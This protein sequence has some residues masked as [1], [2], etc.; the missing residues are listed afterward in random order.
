VIDQF[1][2]YEP[3]EGAETR[4]RTEA[5]VAYDDRYLYIHVRMFDPAPDSI[6]SL[7]ARRDVR[8][9]S[10][11]LKLVIDSYHDRRTAYQFAVNPGGGEAR[12]LRLQR[13]ERGPVVG[14][15]VGRGDGDRFDRGGRRSSASPSASSASPTGPSTPSAC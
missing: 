4:F 3:N 12:L 5:R 8:V 7:L 13:H 2:E 14:R 9:N 11:Q 1:L 6:V 10:E 15:G